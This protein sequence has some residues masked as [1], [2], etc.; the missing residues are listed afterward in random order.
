MYSAHGSN[1]RL[2]YIAVCGIDI[3]DV[4]IP[5]I[6]IV[7]VCIEGIV[8]VDYCGV[9]VGSTFTIL[10]VL[11]SIFLSS[12]LVRM[13]VGVTKLRVGSISVVV[14]SVDYELN[15]SI[16]CVDIR[17]VGNTNSVIGPLSSSLFV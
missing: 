14:R 9:L 12:V 4:G 3:A 11:P 16:V 6:E 10:S 7:D 5:G 8:I 15:R 2:L 17:I 13:G 1:L